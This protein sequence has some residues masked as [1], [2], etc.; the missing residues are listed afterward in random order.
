MVRKLSVIALWKR[1]QF[2]GTFL[3]VKNFGCRIRERIACCVG[4]VV[5]DVP[6]HDASQPLARFEMRAILRDEMQFDP[7][8]WPLELGAHELGVVIARV[9]EI[10]MDERPLK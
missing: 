1:Y 7:A 5:R 10:D 4:F 6:V 3:L 9:V 2:R 8:A